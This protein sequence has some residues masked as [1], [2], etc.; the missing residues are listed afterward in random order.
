M[1]IVLMAF[2]A[3]PLLLPD[4]LAPATCAVQH[5]HDDLGAIGAWRR[6]VLSL[7]ATRAFYD[8]PKGLAVVDGEPTSLA[9]EDVGIDW[10]CGYLV[11]VGHRVRHPRA[12]R[13]VLGHAGSWIGRRIGALVGGSPHR[14]QPMLELPV[15]R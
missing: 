7:R 9:V 6:K 13:I 12:R 11:G 14:T 2:L 5:P 1:N 8:R 10:R 15:A 3:V 4:Y